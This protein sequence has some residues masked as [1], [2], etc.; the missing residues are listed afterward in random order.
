MSGLDRRTFLRGV[1]G[2]A[3]VSVGLP[4]FDGFLN[5]NGT[6]LASGA[7]LPLRF[8]TWFWG[9]GMNP[10]RWNP[11]AEGADYELGPELQAIAGVQEHVT[12]LS[13]FNMNLDGE[14]NHP[15]KSGVMGMLTGTAPP[16]PDDV[17]APTLD[18]LI[19]DELGSATRFRSLEM[20]ATGSAKHSYSRRG[21]NVVNA[22]EVSPLALYTRIFGTGFQ[23]PNA[24]E[25]EPDPRVLLRQSV[26]SAVKDDRTRLESQLGAHDRR[27]LDDYLTALRQLERQLELQL[28]APPPLDACAPP[29]A[30]AEGEVGADIVRARENH[31]LMT[32]LLLM[33]LA[34]DQTRVFNMVF[35]YGASN[36]HLPGSQTGHHT[37]THEELIDPELG[38]QPR[39]T[40]FVGSSMEAWAS[41]VAAMAAFPEGDGTLLDNSLVMA[42]S[43][44]SFAKI[45]DVLGLPIMLAGRAGGRVVPGI[46]VAGR[47]D[48]VTRVGLT[49]Q[50]LMGLSVDRWGTRSMET[51]RG[52]SEIFA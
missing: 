5:V 18:I 7:P 52:I 31:E 25:F 48:P 22:A 19:S 28:S 13:G 49:L 17:P 37:L 11:T 51:N 30:P 12:V 15:H 16:K 20:A 36:L 24:A 9:C 39:A 34:C 35:S 8:G 40:Y 32:K 4:L 45:H 26:I 10:E 6:A 46:H 27:R 3:A 23:D 29:E 21:Q 1:M 41:L 47:G 14:A 33:A 42:H 38:Y 43:E 2:G 44:T 50:Q